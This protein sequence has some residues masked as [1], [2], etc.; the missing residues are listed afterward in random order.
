M[1][2]TPSKIKPLISGK[3]VMGLK[4]VI[5]HSFSSKHYILIIEYEALSS[6][7]I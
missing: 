3:Y 5:C 1:I 2:K 7:E 4:Y 6:V